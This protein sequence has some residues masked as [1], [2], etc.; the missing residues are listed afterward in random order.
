[1]QKEV[2]LFAL[3]WPHFVQKLVATPQTSS[4]AVRSATATCVC[5]TVPWP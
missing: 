5:W 1:V 4:A 3:G 2:T